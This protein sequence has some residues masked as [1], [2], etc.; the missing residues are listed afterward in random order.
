MTMERMPTSHMDRAPRS[1]RQAVPDGPTLFDDDFMN[2]AREAA[3]NAVE[4]TSIECEAPA[5]EQEQVAEEP[6]TDLARKH[7]QLLERAELYADKRGVSLSE[8]VEEVDIEGIHARYVRE[9][10]EKRRQEEA[11]ARQEQVITNTI[12]IGQMR[13]NENARRRAVVAAQYPD[14]SEKQRIALLEFDAKWRA[15]DEIKQRGY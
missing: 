12:A 11:R 4:N 9:Q 5:L 14:G 2:A 10:N 1:R 7:A 6:M 15:A 13:E 3:E 8:A